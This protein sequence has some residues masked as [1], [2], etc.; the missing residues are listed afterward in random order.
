MAEAIKDIR[1]LWIESPE[2][3]SKDFFNSNE[4]IN[5]YFKGVKDGREKEKL[6]QLEKF[7]QNINKTGIDTLK[8]IAN[9]K[10]NSIT[11]ID[12]YLKYNSIYQFQIL[13]LLNEKDIENEK[14]L[15]VY[16]YILEYQNNVATDLYDINFSLVSQSEH[17]N[18]SALTSDGYVLKL[19][20][21]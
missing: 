11:P 5:A 17:F 8:V 6:L 19:A 9:L 10:E 18:F 20:K 1:K 12:A 21:K 2:V 7:T 14:I 3:K 13:I 16:D 15:D 4:L